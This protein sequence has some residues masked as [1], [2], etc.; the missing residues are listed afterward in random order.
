M[1][2]TDQR[3]ARWTARWPLVRNIIL[4]VVGIGLI[5]NEALVHGTERPSLL[6]L[7]AGMI[8]LPAFFSSGHEK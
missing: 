8:G 1:T 4:F 3:L 7:Y 5:I 2:E 6:F